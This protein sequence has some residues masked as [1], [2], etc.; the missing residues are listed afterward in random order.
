MFARQEDDSE[1]QK[2]PSDFSSDIVT[3]GSA[4]LRIVAASAKR[5]P[6]KLV[7]CRDTSLN[8][9]L[10]VECSNHSVPTILFNDLAQ[11]SRVGLFHVRD[12]CG[13]SPR[14]TPQ[15]C[16]F[17]PPSRMTA[18]DAVFAASISCPALGAID[19]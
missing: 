12:F 16:L 14:F 9:V 7:A 17:P 6:S 15:I 5:E 10:G 8:G 3:H 4:L 2:R 19:W 13:T 1:G 11:L 18:Y